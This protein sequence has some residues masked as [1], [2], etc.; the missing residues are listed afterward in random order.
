MKSSNVGAPYLCGVDQLVGPCSGWGNGGAVNTTG[1]TALGDDL[2]GRVGGGA[3]GIDVG[4]VGLEV[5][6]VGRVVILHFGLASLL[7]ENIEDLSWLH[8]QQILRIS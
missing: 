8:H 3:E 7:G 1:Q 5:V 6:C 2:K 4:N